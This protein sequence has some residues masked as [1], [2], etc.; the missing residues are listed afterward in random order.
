[1]TVLDIVEPEP[2]FVP[3]AAFNALRRKALDKLEELMIQS[4]KRTPRPVEEP[5]R[6]DDKDGG[7]ENEQMLE[8]WFYNLDEM[9]EKIVSRASMVPADGNTAALVPLQDYEE[10]LS[11]IHI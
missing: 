1:M 2:A 3:V 7:G 10:A 9:K 4:Y 8:L 5:G 11:L 6:T